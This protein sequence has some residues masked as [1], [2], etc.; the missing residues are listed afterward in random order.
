[1]TFDLIVLASVAALVILSMVIYAMGLGRGSPLS[2]ESGDRTFVLGSFLRDWFYWALGPVLR[3]SLAV[4]AT[5][6]FFNFLG[7]AFAMTAGA[8][9]ASGRLPL[10]G[11]FILLGGIC[12][13]LDGRV[14]RARGMEA[15]YGAFLDSVLDRFAEVAAFVGLAVFFSFEPVAAPLLVAAAGGSLIVS[16]ARAR[17][18]SL[19]VVCT[20]GVMQRAERLLLLG[21]SAIADPGVSFLVGREVPG[22]LLLPAVALIGLGTFGTAIYRTVWIVRQLV[23]EPRESAGG[24]G[25]VDTT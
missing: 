3:V 2:E 4:G 10:G 20:S 9:F 8:C 21:L 6:V 11:S 23:A 1:M 15:P 22:G 17:G 12:D 18:E 13:S 5:P 7:L 25:S 14:A 19:G 16:Y 24:E